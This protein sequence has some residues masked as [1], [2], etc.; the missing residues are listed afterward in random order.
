MRHW[1]GP[2]GCSRG[3]TQAELGFAIAA[4]LLG[5]ALRVRFVVG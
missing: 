5:E 3:C 1:V 2:R 4:E